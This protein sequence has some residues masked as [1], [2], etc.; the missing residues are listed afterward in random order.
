MP[1]VE[2]LMIQ[3]DMLEPLVFVFLGDVP[4]MKIRK[5]TRIAPGI[6]AN[7]NSRGRLVALELLG[8]VDLDYVMNEVADRFDA[9]QLG[10]LERRRHAIEE[11]LSSPVQ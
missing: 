5:S 2:S 7:V 3:I 8:P 4:R 11:V 10:Q 1:E 6:I 9:P